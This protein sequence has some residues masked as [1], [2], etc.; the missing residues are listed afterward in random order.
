MAHV[1][2][3]RMGRVPH[4]DSANT[5]R[6]AGS[7]FV[8][9]PPPHLQRQERDFGS[10]RDVDRERQLRERLLESKRSR[11]DGGDRSR[12]GDDDGRD[13]RFSD[14]RGD[15]DG[16]GYGY[17]G[18]SRGRDRDDDDRDRSY[19]DRSPRGEGGRARR[20]SPSYDSHDTQR[21][22]DY[23]R[24][25]PPPPRF[26]GPPRP[27]EDRYEPPRRDQDARAGNMY[28]PRNGGPLESGGQDGGA[29]GGWRR[30][31]P[32]FGD[33][34]DGSFFESRNQQRKASTL[35]IWPPSPKS[36]LP[37]SEDE[38]EKERER[39]RKSKGRSSKHS[40]SR[41]KHKS[42]SSSHRDRDRHS[43]SRRHHS[44]RSKHTSSSSK[45]RRDDSD[46]E[47][48]SDR[49]DDYDDDED[50]RHKS[51]S[52]KHHRH[53]H[54]RS[55]HDREDRPRSRSDRHRS[56]DA[57]EDRERRRS[58]RSRSARPR[59]RSVSSDES[60]SSDRSAHRRHRSRS[61]SKR[62]R[63]RGAD[64]KDIDDEL[65]RYD[66]NRDEW[67]RGLKRAKKGKGRGGDGHDDEDDDDEEEVGPQLP[68]ADDGKP[69]DPRAYGGALRPG[70]GSAMAAF[71]QE[72][73][74][75]P[76]RGEIGLTPEQIEAYE[77]AGF[78]MSGSRHRRMNAVRI[79]KENQV[80][81]AE[82]KRSILKMQAEEKAKK[83]AQI[84]AQFREMVDTLTPGGAP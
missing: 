26:D 59:S 53:R 37:D 55:S 27:Y 40:S 71:L 72:G 7:T 5:D 73:K 57:K 2:P 35:S 83:E 4:S 84:V 62:S 82:E 31:P 69:I 12:G 70:E 66:E 6:N 11:D 68:V 45:R 8:R 23:S 24:P 38:R 19:R 43:S 3:S 47:S 10:S 9:G 78:V 32:Q 44:S 50:R 60:S 15:G 76:R 74:R 79:R 36:P 39:K 28:P 67:E 17:D 16:D 58:T 34:T 56:E 18:S 75:I 63:S 42:S 22:G 81:S 13:R 20:P 41:H 77:K 21:R 46:D 52:S 61:A 54:H 48:E 29:G 33:A 25:P 65:D 1:H 14:R 49:S 64:G 51:R 80:I 30:G